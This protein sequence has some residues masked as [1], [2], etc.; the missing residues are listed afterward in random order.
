[1]LPPTS[2]KVI[3]THVRT[4][5]GTPVI[6]GGLVQQEVSDGS[7]RT[8]GLGEIPG[9]DLLFSSRLASQENTELVMYIVPYI[10]IPES[11]KD[12]LAAMSAY[13]AQHYGGGEM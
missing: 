3:S 4:Q 6:I 9:A 1:S 2:E 8:P 5:A 7:S 11:D 10:D 13:Y 12:P